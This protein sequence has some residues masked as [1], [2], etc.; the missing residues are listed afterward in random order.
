MDSED[1]EEV[2]EL[3]RLTG[4]VPLDASFLG[5]LFTFLGFETEITDREEV[6]RVMRVTIPNAVAS[7]NDTP[8]SIA[9]DFAI[10]EGVMYSMVMLRIIQSVYLSGCMRAAA[11]L[12][13]PKGEWDGPEDYPPTV[14]AKQ[15][16]L[17]ESRLR[18]YSVK[19]PEAMKKL[20]GKVP[21]SFTVRF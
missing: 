5:E 17:W 6:G 15:I 10:D 14:M 7:D 8:T 3:Q 11:A 1:E 16:A 12:I 2:K 21:V 13:D 19:V 20:E 9:V 4:R 18:E